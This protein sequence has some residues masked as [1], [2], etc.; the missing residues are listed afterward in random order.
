MAMLPDQMLQAVAREGGE[1]AIDEL[2]SHVHPSVEKIVRVSLI[3]TLTMQI[4]AHRN[5]QHELEEINN[6]ATHEVNIG[7]MWATW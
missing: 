5:H 7:P 1:V 6:F 4:A 3:Q 2:M